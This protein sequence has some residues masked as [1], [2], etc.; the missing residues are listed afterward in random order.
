MPRFFSSLSA[1]CSVA[2]KQG[3]SRFYLLLLS[4]GLASCASFQP[5]QQPAAATASPQK[6]DVSNYLVRELRAPETYGLC[7]ARPAPI[8]RDTRRDAL[9]KLAR[10]QHRV[11]GGQVIDAS[12]GIVSVGYHE[13]EFD[14]GKADGMPTWQRVAGFWASL[15][16]DWP[17]TFESPVE[18]KVDRKKLYQ[19]IAM[20]FAEASRVRGEGDNPNANDRELQAVHSAFLRNALVDVPWSAAFIS[21][22]MKS[23]GFTASEFEFSDSH[24]DYVEGAFIATML[25]LDRRPSAYAYRA[26]DI[27]STAPRVGDMLCQTRAG[28]SKS[29]TFESLSADLAGRR[30]QA[31]PASL[32]MHCDVVVQAG[33]GGGQVLEVIGGNVFQSVTLR[34]MTLDPAGLLAK[35]YISSETPG[36]CISVENCPGHLNYRPWSVLLQL[37]NSP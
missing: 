29:N 10:E 24:V 20:L 32:P 19:Q 25:E 33:E 21:F 11:F 16:P 2:L 37:R 1:Y 13:A 27:R 28:S 22:L 7:A 26:C 30:G 36:T 4:L 34:K 15:D 6:A 35:A 5:A 3:R 9:I 14:H 8:V 31:R 17:L 23:T 18:E 12:G